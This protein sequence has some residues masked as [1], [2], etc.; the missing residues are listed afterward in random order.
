MVVSRRAETCGSAIRGVMMTEIET[1]KEPGIP[2]DLNAKMEGFDLDPRWVWIARNGRINAALVASPCHG[3]VLVW[4]LVVRKDAPVD[5][6]PLL[7]RR[8]V[9]DCKERGYTGVFSYLD[10][11]R[12]E[13]LFF[14]KAIVN[15][16]GVVMKRPQ[17]VAA[18]QFSALERW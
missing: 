7:L 8:F 6:L 16:N 11:K 3:T 18:A 2:E 12:P 10:P 15:M 1:L 13:E 14:M 5:T 17:F 4:R 9:R